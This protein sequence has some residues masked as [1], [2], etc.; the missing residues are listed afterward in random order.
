MPSTMPSSSS[1]DDEKR[2]YS[3]DDERYEGKKTTKDKKGGGYTLNEGF[4]ADEEGKN[5]N[6]KSPSSSSGKKK[7][8]KT[9]IKETVSNKLNFDRSLG[10]LQASNPVRKMCSKVANSIYFSRAILFVVILNGVIVAL[11]TPDRGVEMYGT[12]PHIPKDVTFWLGNAFLILFGLEAIVKIVAY[13]FLLNGPDSYMWSYW[14]VFDLFI[15]ITGILDVILDGGGWITT[16]RLMKCFQPLKALSKYKAGRMVMDTAEKALPMMIDVVLLLLWFVILATVMGVMLFGTIMS[17]RNYEDVANLGGD[18]KERCSFLVSN[19]GTVDGVSISRYDDG[20]VPGDEELCLNSDVDTLVKN[21]TLLDGVESNVYC[22]DSGVSPFDNYL[23][24]DNFVRG[25]FIVLHVITIDGWNELAWPVANTAGYVPAMSYFC[26]VA[27]LGGFFVFQLFTAVICATLGEVEEDDDPEAHEKEMEELREAHEKSLEPEEA[28]P[29]LE[30]ACAHKPRQMILDITNH[31]IFQNF[32]TFTI[33]VNTGL[34]CA[35]HVDKTDSFKDVE[36]IIDLT[37]SGIFLFEFVLKH[38]GLGVVRYWKNN[39]NKLDGFVVLVS[40]IDFSL[41]YGMSNSGGDEEGGTPVDLSFLRV[42]R[43]FRILRTLKIVRNNAE[44]SKIANS[45]ISATQ[46][47]WVFLL[48]WL[49]F[50]AIF[51]ILGVQLF[52][53]RESFDEERLS[54]KNFGSAL[55]TLFAVSTGENTFEVAWSSMKVTNIAAGIYMIIWCF[56]TTAVLAL[57]LGILIDAIASETFLIEE[58]EFHKEGATSVIEEIRKRATSQS[59]LGKTFVEEEN[60]TDDDENGEHYYAA[61]RRAKAKKEKLS[62]ADFGRDDNESRVQRSVQEVAVVRQWLVSI[63]FAHHTEESLKIQESLRPGHVVRARKRLTCYRERRVKQAKEELKIAREHLSEKLENVR[64]I[65]RAM[66]LR[67]NV[68]DSDDIWVKFDQEKMNPDFVKPIF[69][70]APE[71]LMSPQMRDVCE[72]NCQ[73][74]RKYLAIDPVTGWGSFRWRCLKIATN[75]WFDTLILL[76]IIASSAMMATNTQRWPVAGTKVDDAYNLIDIIFNAVFTLEMVLKMIGYGIWKGPGAYLKTGFNRLDCFVV[77]SSLVTYAVG[78]AIPVKTLRILRVLRPLRT[79][80]RLPGL[81]LVI[82]VILQSLPAIKYVCIIGFGMMIVLGI[83]GMELFLGQMASCTLAGGE[84]TRDP[85]TDKSNLDKAACLEQGGV[86]RANRF[87]FDNIGQAIITIFI[88]STGDNWQDIMYVAMDSTGDDT[89]PERDAN[90]GAAAFFVF[91]ILFAMMLWANLFVSALVDNFT[92]L[93]SAGVTLTTEKQREWQ[94]AML[95]ANR[96]HTNRW[97]KIVPKNPMRK[98]VHSIIA[99]DWF[100]KLSITMIV[101]NMFVLIAYRANGSQAEMDFQ[102][103]A[104]YIFTVWYC[105]ESLFLITGMGW[106]LY[107]ESMWNKIDFVVAWSGGLGAIL[108]GILPSNIIRMVRFFRLLK[109][110]Q[111]FKGLR[112]LVLTAVSAIPGVINVSALSLLV[113]FIFSCLGV[114]L[115]GN[116]TGPFDVTK[117]KS[118]GEY[119]NFS[120]FQ[121]AFTALFIAFSGNWQGFFNDL[122]VKEDCFSVDAP[123]PGSEPKCSPDIASAFFFVIYVVLSIFLFGNLFV[124]ILLERF[125]FAHGEEIDEDDDDDD[126]NEGEGDGKRDENDEPYEGGPIQVIIASVR[127]R[128]I[129]RMFSQ[130]IKSKQELYVKGLKEGGSSF[131]QQRSMNQ[132]ENNNTSSTLGNLASSVPSSTDN[133][134]T[135]VYVSSPSFSRQFTLRES[136]ETPKANESYAEWKARKKKAAAS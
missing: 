11:D 104:G 26:A 114:S 101:L 53:A 103:Y 41:T 102:S 23:N 111:V 25:M 88:I 50:L 115:F 113:I 34:M 127:L 15:V 55:I 123:E 87:N 68:M 28:Y 71:R 78:D 10:F 8:K 134:K 17:G 31:P 86:W 135:K 95:I 126:D 92:T 62:A 64:T 52:A 43:V 14:N 49:M 80:Q 73:Q 100:D 66:S 79:I 120:N 24:F 59:T 5:N 7:K 108:P 76:L 85:L 45:A 99:T 30:H 37:C 119:S 116:D 44:F 40:I 109:V 125:T 6:N 131:L 112:T 16:L 38:I 32:I 124:A 93:A 13:G 69:M 129:L 90:K 81:K 118:I 110:I 84:D 35:N 4:K 48:V 47:M 122:Y 133:S 2:S 3:Y 56:I 27:V 106:Y 51:A 91:S 121:R 117:L 75:F 33:L 130:K 36:L 29:Q 9:S 107:W 63:G 18:P 83:T 60:S 94:Q 57:I 97:R 96:V 128:Q 39:W 19:Y 72:D 22:C 65:P 54:F 21:A 82:T 67:C 98:K 58:G 89:A 46:N 74:I 105:L 136:A 20:G 61:K 1:D 77:L 12:K 42:F 70:R 132:E